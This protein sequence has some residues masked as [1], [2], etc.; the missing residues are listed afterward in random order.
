MNC[1][2]NT[3]E[4]L[5]AW[6]DGELPPERARELQ[7]HVRECPECA[8][9]VRELDRMAALL[10]LLP[11]HEP[12]LDFARR[13]RLEADRSGRI[14]ALPARISRAHL[15]LHRVAAGA[16]V[17]TGVV[18]GVLAGLDASAPA[19]PEE[20]VLARPRPKTSRVDPGLDVFAAAPAGSITEAALA[21]YSEAEGGRR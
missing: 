12:D 13:V 15:V 3:M 20:A 14:L 7:R 11:S 8:A 6:R 2:Y 4:T 10:N 9:S 5:G 17:L 19:A 1:K 21:F 16:L 18:A